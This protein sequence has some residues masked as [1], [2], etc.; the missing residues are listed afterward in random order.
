MEADPTFFAF[1][2]EFDSIK[3]YAPYT[4]TGSVIVTGAI[5]GTPPNNFATF[6]TS[7]ILDRT[8][9]IIQ[10]QATT[11][12]DAGK[13]YILY[14]GTAFPR[15][16]GANNYGVEFSYVYGPSTLT[17]QALVSNPYGV[18]LNLTTETITFYIKTFIAPFET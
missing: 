10:V 9:T 8:S 5:S 2:S 14:P 17:V 7:I 12:A 4:Y 13:T 1:N 18:T 6:S 16:D 11:T 3:N 15:A